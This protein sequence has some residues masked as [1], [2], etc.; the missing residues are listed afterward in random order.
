MKDHPDV[1]TFQRAQ[2]KKTA[3][4]N[5]RM[6]GF[7]GE[8][9]KR[10]L[11]LFLKWETLITA[12]CSFILGRAV[13]L[14]AMV[15]F[16]LAAMAA[17]MTAIPDRG[18]LVLL[19]LS[20][21][22][23]TVLK[24]Q[25][26]WSSVI[27]L[28]FCLIFAGRFSYRLKDKWYGMPLFIWAL[29]TVG[30]VGFYAYREPN[31]YNYIVAL[32]EG[33]VAAAVTYVF[34]RALPAL[35]RQSDPYALRRD[36]LLG[37][38]VLIVGLLTGLSGVRLAVIDLRNVVSR[39]FILLA[40]F[41]GG[42]S[43]GAAMGTLV[44]M[45]PSLS[46]A[47][48]PGIIGFYSFAGLLSGLFRSFG[49]IGIIIGFSLGNIILSIYLNNYRVLAAD[50][51]ETALAAVIFMVL[52]QK[53]LY[54]LRSLI[55]G[56]LAQFAPRSFT[57]K[58]LREMTSARVREFARVFQEL[59]NTIEQVACDARAREEGGLQALFGNISSKVCKGCS[60][61]RVCWEK[62][63]YKTYKNIMDL[64]AT[65][66][67]TGR[68][69]VDNI[70]PEIKKRCVR[71]KELAVT[72]NCLFD[73]YRA[74]HF[75]ERKVT[76]SREVV[77][78]QL[79][80]ISSILTNLAGEIKLDVQ[81]REDIELI[82][83]RE[84]VR[85][86]H[87]VLDLKVL[88]VGGDKLEVVISCP[89]CGGKLQCREICPLVA[90]V[91]GQRMKVLNS[92]YCPKKTGEPVCEFRLYPAFKY[93]VEIGVASASCDAEVSGDNYSVLE[94]KD[95]KFVMILSDGMGIGAKAAQE[96]RATIG[97]LEQLMETGFDKALAV[98]TV[99]SVLVVRSPEETFATVDLTIIDLFT[100]TADFMKIGAVPSFIKRG[101]QVGMVR[102]ASLPIG[103]LNN[104][105]VDS[106]QKALSSEDVVVMVTDG[107]LEAGRDEGKNEE[108]V[109]DTLQNVMTTDP[110][111]I[112]DLILNKAIAMNR[113]KVGD[114]MTVLVG[115]VRTVK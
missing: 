19:F 97:L 27:V 114:D 48:A 12:L 94:L 73:L 71:L 109:L 76:E 28:V 108:W 51:G 53:V 105:D 95:G 59:S 10:K 68:V 75:W 60:L 24:G 3:G 86:G 13:V 25:I 83:R 20:A 15:P 11:F 87:S 99:N 90:G 30:R 104:I 39:F 58:R 55:R 65:I 80:G 115:V 21:G 70:S 8:A 14:G 111:N 84:L 79:N 107:I 32:F 34:I 92:N 64:F 91:L 5:R 47:L 23:A 31:L 63:F 112:A 49:R 88:S 46:A 38:A 18:P 50:L 72:V 17:V 36:E 74:N 113:G 101:S 100:G 77:A 43:L 57:E 45:V 4:K 35:R 52:P 96:S 6:P 37:L 62:D 56:S 54:Y 69:T 22:I 29:T 98:K 89:S 40:S 66:E 93:E 44:G 61:Y 106:I 33:L 81:M 103:I 67:L 2:Q 42:G 16:A 82:L 85:A 102:S 41:T 78:G 1:Y 110:Q 9:L 7:S 26:F